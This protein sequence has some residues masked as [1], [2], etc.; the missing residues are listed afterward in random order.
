MK[1]FFK[2]LSFVMALAMI[3]SVIAPAA[4][5]FAADSLALSVKGT[6]YLYLG[7]ATKS[8]LDV[9]LKGTK[10]VGAK[11]LWSS[12][13]KT[14]AT[15]DK[16]GVV[17]G[18]KQGKTTVSL[19][20]TKKDG[21][22]TT[23]SV[24]FVV[25]NNIKEFTSI[26]DADGA[27]LDKLV[28]NKAYD[29]NGKFT[30]NGGSTTSTSSVAR[31]S[32]DSDKATIDVKTGVFTATE[33]GTYK[34]TVNAFETATGADAWVALNDKT[35]TA[36][37]KA[38]GTF[39][40]TVITSLVSSKQ[41]DKDTLELTFDGDMSKSTLDKDLVLYRV[42][43]SSTITTG[44]EKV[45]KVSY[46]TTGKIATV[47]F[48]AS[49]TAGDS[50]K[51]VAGEL[52]VPFTAAKVALT[53]VDKIAFDAVKVK[54]TDTAGVDLLASVKALNKDGVVI[55][56]GSEI[57][58]YLTFTYGGE[59][60]K[61]FISGTKLYLYTEGT[62][63]KVTAT[64]S[65]WYVNE[66]N[67][68]TE[69]KTS[70]DTVASVYKLDANLNAASISYVL[71]A[72]ATATSSST[73]GW[74]SSF[75]VPKGDSGL[76]ISAKYQT[77]DI[78]D[79]TFRYTDNNAL[80]TYTSN[81]PS[82][83]LVTGYQLTAL[84]E[85]SV[86]IVVKTAADGKVVG[87]FTVNVGPARALASVESNVYAVTLG[88]NT[89]PAV[90][91]SATVKLTV[92]DTSGTKYTGVGVTPTILTAPTG[93]TLTGATAGLVAY[94][95]NAN[96]GTVDVTFNGS[97]FVVPGAYTFKLEA[98]TLGASRSVIVTVNVLNGTDTTVARYVP[99][100]STTSVDLK[101]VSGAAVVVPQIYGYNAA[102]ARV[103]K[104]TLGSDF[105]YTVATTANVAVT[106]AFVN[107]TGV[108]V[109]S[110]SG[111]ST[112]VT[113]VGIGNYRIDFKTIGSLSN[114]AAVVLYPAL[115]DLG[116]VLFEVKDSSTLTVGVEKTAVAHA[117]GITVA[118]VAAAAFKLTVNGVVVDQT[119]DAA[120]ITIEGKIGSGAAT[121]A[122]TVAKGESV[123]IEKIIYSGAA[124]GS[125]TR[126]VTFTVNQVVTLN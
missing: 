34:V 21:K 75:N 37:V 70:A 47:D 81:D 27:D 30:T 88:N 63:A 16:Y 98:G 85:G 90:A 64:F 38:T 5:A 122:S 118:Q 58:S 12:S 52:S 40:V 95:A 24:D 25:R 111:A 45:K 117:T 49:F 32:V 96:D 66:S 55:Y 57:S 67:V 20:I 114:G 60:G 100:L 124:G 65:N 53:E 79:G 33:A 104:L 110:L 116:S 8:S 106:G 10:P 115:A 7:N 9:N 120:K 83:V 26:V 11:Y 112:H 121:G 109:V 31:W 125:G 72:A 103:A 35:S 1:N 39:E 71:N 80:F 3:V 22:K 42:V 78:T 113:N 61:G 126:T 68:Y 56:T 13:K 29:L 14:V 74:A 93:S 51:L 92:K 97:L 82:K 6:K 46:D 91:E 28:A 44:A 41:V 87:V 48:Y 99:T 101:T 123:Y 69:F 50:Y 105:S 84:N 86:D 36:G 94:T 4:G 2:K 102:G 108:E 43:G 89:N 77:N 15:V 73:T 59:A 62:T 107:N 17:K 18:V 119:V 19:A 54:T 23:L 76:Y